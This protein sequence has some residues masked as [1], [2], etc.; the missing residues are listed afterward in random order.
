[1]LSRPQPKVHAQETN[2]LDLRDIKGQESAKRALE[3]AAA[4]GHHLLMMDRRRGQIDAGGTAALDIAAAVAVGTVGSVDDRLGRRRNPRRRADRKTAVPQP[5]SFR[6]HGRAHRRR[7]AGKARRDFAGASGRAVPRRTAGI[8]SAR[9]GFA[10]PALG[11]RRGRGVP[12][13]SPRHLSRPLH[14]G[15]GDESLPLRPCLRARLFLQARPHRPL[16]HP[17]TRRASRAR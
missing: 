15:R 17:T 13:Q 7:H 10:A 2:S 5:P 16:Q 8:R 6:Q 9:A 4:G 14:A 11:K 1:V 12:C 3:I